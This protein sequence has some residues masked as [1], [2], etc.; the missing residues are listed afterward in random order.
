VGEERCIAIADRI[1]I[2][3]T[4][5]PREVPGEVEHQGAAAAALSEAKRT[6]AAAFTPEPIEACTN[7]ECA[8]HCCTCGAACACGGGSDAD[9]HGVV[10]GSCKP[11]EAT[12]TK[13][14]ICLERVTPSTACRL[15]CSHVFRAECIEGLRDLGVQQVCPLCR[16]TLP[17]SVEQLQDQAINQ[18][19]RLKREF[20]L[21][22]K[23]FT[24]RKMTDSQKAQMD[25][26][27]ASLRQAAEQGHAR[28]NLNLGNLFREGVGVD[29]DIAEAER[30]ILAAAEQG[31]PEAQL[32]LGIENMKKRELGQASFWFKKAADQ[33]NATAQLN[34]GTVKAQESRHEEAVV[35]Y[36]MAAGKG[37]AK[38]QFNL[39]VMHEKGL[40]VE[41]STAEAIRWYTMAAAQGSVE[42]HC[43]VGVIYHR[44][45][46]GGE[47][48][49]WYTEAAER[50]DAVA[51]RGIGIMYSQG[52]G[53]EK[54]DLKARQFFKRAALK[55]DAEAK[56]RLQKT[57]KSSKKK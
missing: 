13:C 52:H 43:N 32:T 50:G 48:L 46:K 16:H 22:N 7:A 28:S 39:A 3:T 27:V 12:N 18:F 21:N 31:E 11:S 38:A 6:F 33:G 44:Q 54:C 5:P 10:R 55:G 30:C 4:S 45:G 2:S 23:S 19:W 56:R 14:P 17:P 26:V 35:Y 40:G 24:R 1:P 53:V 49:K 41:Q 29:R 37:V 42:A 25:E 51:L 34:L 15:P 47:A 57:S 8:F 20:E 36:T 9:G